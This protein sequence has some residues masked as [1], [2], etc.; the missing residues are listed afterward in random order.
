MRTL[1]KIMWNF[2]VTYVKKCTFEGQWIVYCLHAMCRVEVSG[3][4]DP[5]KF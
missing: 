4:H 1:Y 5:G 3:H 2:Q